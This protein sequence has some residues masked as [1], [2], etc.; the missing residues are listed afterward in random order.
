MIE[1]YGVLV[2]LVYKAPE[3]KKTFTYSRHNKMVDIFDICS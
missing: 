1:C 3:R 2:V